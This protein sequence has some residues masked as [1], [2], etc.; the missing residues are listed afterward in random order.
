VCHIYLCV[1]V[2]ELH[3]TREHPNHWE[4]QRIVTFDQILHY[5]SKK[6]VVVLCKTCEVVYGELKCAGFCA[7]SICGVAF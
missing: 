5:G 2:V 7:L 4:L 6:G 1:N 3:I